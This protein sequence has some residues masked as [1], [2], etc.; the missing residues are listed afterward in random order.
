MRFVVFRLATQIFESF[1]TAPN[2]A[3]NSIR[4]IVNFSADPSVCAV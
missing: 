2:S 1:R 3:T 4:K